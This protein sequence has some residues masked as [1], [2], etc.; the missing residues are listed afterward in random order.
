MDQEPGG[1]LFCPLISRL[2][3]PSLRLKRLRLGRPNF[4]ITI[5][6]NPFTTYACDKIWL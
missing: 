2:G 1:G 6:F 5:Y 3:D 4:N